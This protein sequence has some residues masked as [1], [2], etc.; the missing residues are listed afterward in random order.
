MQI[1]I[2][3]QVRNEEHPEHINK[4]MEFIDDGEVVASAHCVVNL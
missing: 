4:Q 3:S 1:I 2:S